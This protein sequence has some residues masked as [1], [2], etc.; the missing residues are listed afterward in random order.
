MST[1]PS[2]L[3]KRKSDDEGPQGRRAKRN[4]PQP[5]P[6]LVD[7]DVPVLLPPPLKKSGTLQAALTAAS[8][9][10]GDRVMLKKLNESLRQIRIA[11]LKKIKGKG[12]DPAEAV[13]LCLKTLN[14]SNEA[15]DPSTTLMRLIAVYALDGDPDDTL[16]KQGVSEYRE[17]KES[18]DALLGAAIPVPL[19]YTADSIAYEQGE[20]PTA[21]QDWPFFLYLLREQKQS[22]RP[23]ISTGLEPLDE[24]IGGLLDMTIVAGDTGAGKTSLVL[25]LAVGA[26]KQSANVGALIYEAE[27]G[28]TALYRRL[29]SAESGVPLRRFARSDASETDMA[30]V[31]AANNHFMA[32]VLPRLRI[33]DCPPHKSGLTFERMRQDIKDF[34]EN[35]N[36]ERVVIV[37][38]SLQL[39]SLRAS[40]FEPTDSGVQHRQRQTEVEVAKQKMELLMAMQRWTRHL[41]SPGGF[42][43]LVTSRVRKTTSKGRLELADVYGSVDAVF[44][45]SC[46]LLVEPSD[47]PSIPGVTP[48]MLNVAKIRD[49]G[50]TG[51]IRLDFHHEIFTFKDRK[52]T[53]PTKASASRSKAT[54]FAGKE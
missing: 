16:W 50:T 41:S 1:K 13:G 23:G 29:T 38:D 51:D 49:W 32:S 43:F 22:P 35:A 6:E 24:R 10:G 30:T 27:V 20:Q 28:K 42:P 18:Y 47:E 25:Q 7:S 2:K 48:C 52:Q 14:W 12:C 21:L 53:P 17:K 4:R 5:E 54:R 45:S 40:T 36:V 44:N 26:V 3:S 34:M 37:V 46:I 8:L 11:C 9:A 33:I 19:H 31:R 15:G 39:M